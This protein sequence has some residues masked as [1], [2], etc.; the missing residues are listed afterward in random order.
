V[1]WRIQNSDVYYYDEVTG[2][3]VGAI[4]Y[5][6]HDTPWGPCAKISYTFGDTEPCADEVDCQVTG[7]PTVAAN[8]T[9][10]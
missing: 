2:A 7:D 1:V 6:G 8:W 4:D 5:G 9:C 10:P 3:L